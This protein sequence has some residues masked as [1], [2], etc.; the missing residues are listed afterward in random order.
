[1]SRNFSDWFFVM[2]CGLY[3]FGLLSQRKSLL[4][5]YANKHCVITFTH[6]YQQCIK[7]TNI[8]VKI[9]LELEP[10]RFKDLV[11]INDLSPIKKFFNHEA[12]LLLKERPKMI[13][14]HFL[15]TRFFLFSRDW[16]NIEPWLWC[17][18]PLSHWKRWTSDKISSRWGN[19]GSDIRSLSVGIFRFFQLRDWMLECCDRMVSSLMKQLLQSKLAPSLHLW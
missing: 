3:I 12:V 8:I 5:F 2:S 7:Y 18:I 16:C 4:L 14:G 1:M 13:T 15:I 19:I 6:F 17:R 9:K 11:V 10:E